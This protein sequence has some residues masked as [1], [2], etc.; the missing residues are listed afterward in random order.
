MTRRFAGAISRRRMMFVGGTLFLVTCLVPLSAQADLYDDYINSSS[1]SPFVAF[2]ARD[3]FPGHAFVAVGVHLD[4]GLMV[5]ERFFG[6]YPISDSKLAEAKLVFSKTTG[7]LDY[8]WKD[9]A[10]QVNYRVA[11]PEDKKSAVMAV[12]DKWKSNDPKYNLFALGGKNC[13][14]FAGE[15]AV[16]AGLKVVD[17]AGSM[18]PIDYI[19]KLRQANGG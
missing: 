1:K 6:Y 7:Q 3:G 9:T 10:W 17:G 5:Y 11:I 8:K 19:K 14:A 4:S 16:A 18:L 15:V 13:S 2:L 12:V